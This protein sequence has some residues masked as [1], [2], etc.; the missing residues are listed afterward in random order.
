MKL[1]ILL[2]VLL[3]NLTSCQTSM[4]NQDISKRIIAETEKAFEQMVQEKGI[5]K[6][7]YHFADENA[8]LKREN[9]SLIIGKENIKTYYQSKDLKNVTLHWTPDFIDVS[10]D[11]SMA[12]TYGKFLM[13]VTN[14]DATITEHKGVFHTVWKKQIDGSWKYVWD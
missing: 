2:V 11:E 12:Y 5:A 14:A 13:K 8:V 4:N 6:A 10:E 1:P 3:I 9:D 7:F